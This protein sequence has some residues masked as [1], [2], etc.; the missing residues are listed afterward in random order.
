[1]QPPPGAPEAMPPVKIIWASATPVRLAVLKLRSAGQPISE[2]QVSKASQPRANYVIAIVGLPAPDAGSDPHAL[3]RS[4]TLAVK[5]KP[6]EQAADSEYRY[7]GSA[8]V[9]FFRF[10]RAALSI[11]AA[12]VS[13][14]FAA[15][16]GQVQIKHKFPLGAMRFNGQLAL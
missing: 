12:D 6:P 7:I 1:M 14:E 8:D 15:R 3:A 11:T 10:P 16:F 9:Y 5:G 2:E 4:A 13:A